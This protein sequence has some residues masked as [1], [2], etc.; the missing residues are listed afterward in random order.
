MA[1]QMAVVGVG[2][3]QKVLSETL[4]VPKSNGRIWRHGRRD[5]TGLTPISCRNARAPKRKADV[6]P[7]T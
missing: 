6:E 4:S 5:G 1:A 2:I 7:S 3:S